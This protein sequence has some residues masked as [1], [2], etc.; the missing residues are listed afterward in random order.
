LTLARS[1]GKASDPVMRQRLAW[2]YARVETMRFLGYRVLS[3][4]LAGKPIGAAASASKLYWSEYHRVAT[5]LALDLEGR[6]GMIPLGR[7]PSRPLRA[8]DPG[9]DPLSTASWWEVAL[10]ARAGTIYAGTSE[11]Q[12]TILAEQ[13]LGLPRG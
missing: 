11:V 9:A 10:N 6:N 3:D 5:Q 1:T 13:A 7:G 4:V 8:D 2:C 12:R